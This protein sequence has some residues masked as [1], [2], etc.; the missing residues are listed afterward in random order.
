MKQIYL[1]KNDIFEYPVD[2]LADG[3]KAISDIVSDLFH[4]M[5]LDDDHYGSD[6]WN[7]LGAYIAP[8]DK[9]L[10]KPNLVRHRNLSSNSQSNGLDS[11]IT[12]PNLINV[13]CD[14]CLAAL[15][16]KGAVIIG[17]SPMQG[18]DFEALLKNSGLDQLIPHYQS[19]GIT[20]V[21]L[22]D[23]RA[24]QS[25]IGNHG[26]IVSRSY[27]DNEGVLV[28]LGKDSMH[29]SG[30]H[31]Y[32]VSDYDSDDVKKYHSGDTHDYLIA[33]DVL[34]ADVIIN[35][36]K[37]KTHRLAGFTGCMKNMVGIAYEKAA[38]PHY[39][40]GS[41]KENGDSYKE[42][43][44]AKRLAEGLNE[45]Q[46]KNEAGGRKLL[47]VI[48]HYAVSSL[49]HIGSLF[50]KNWIYG[51]AWHGNDTIWRTV[52]DLNLICK[53]SDKTGGLHEDPQRKILNI[54][55]MIIAGEGAGPVAPT[56]KPLGILIAGDDAEAIDMAICKLMGFDPCRIPLVNYLQSKVSNNQQDIVVNPMVG[57]L[58][59]SESL[60]NFNFPIEWK[61][62]PHSTWNE[63][64]NEH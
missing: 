11:L 15:K 50:G 22:V 57:G 9:V 6:D 49:R 29:K 19:L 41:V 16:G 21:K 17:D 24:F 33:K 47:A 56:A 55:D 64:L 3:N 61:F 31:Q 14:Y 39:V 37:P 42:P 30:D 38:L 10:I 23:F 60:K 52:C 53:Y 4:F 59:E 20:N 32:C 7:P 40:A 13:I 58:V 36:C 2:F 44:L 8:G 46:A 5:K 54:C 62:K 12:S 18:C 45:K 51:G 26:T 27:N 1:T 25:Q 35:L 63:A 28:H 48:D 34:E 43:S